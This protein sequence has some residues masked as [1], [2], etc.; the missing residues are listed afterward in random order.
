MHP[1]KQGAKRSTTPSGNPGAG[2]RADVTIT[3]STGKQKKPGEFNW[4][5]FWIEMG[6]YALIFNIVAG[7]ITWYYIFPKL[8]LR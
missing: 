2:T 3:R 5:K 1:T 7:L 4:V 8:H 6:I